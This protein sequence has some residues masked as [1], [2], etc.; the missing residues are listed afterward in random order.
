MT[1]SPRT[2][3]KGLYTLAILASLTLGLAP[4]FPEPHLVGKWRWLLGGAVG[5]GA[6]DWA[7]LAM[8]S[9]PFI[10]L[11]ALLIGDL[12]SRWKPKSDK[13]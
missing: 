6:M 7:D 8:H 1:H 5:M 4:Y 9:A 2:S 3:R 10:F 13:A 12:K 11:L